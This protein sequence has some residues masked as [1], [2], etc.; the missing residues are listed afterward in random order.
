MAFPT[1]N[2]ARELTNRK[3]IEDLQLQKKQMLLKQGVVNNSSSTPVTPALQVGNLGNIAGGAGAG[4]MQ[5]MS[6]AQRTAL[7]HAHT[8]SFGFFVTNVS[9]F[10]NSILPVLPRFDNN[11]ARE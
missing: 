5:A 9:S 11:K 4:D 2:N 6:S 1:P 10:G 8:Q 3:I 7:M